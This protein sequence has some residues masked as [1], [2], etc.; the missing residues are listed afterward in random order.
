[1]GSMTRVT[2]AENVDFTWKG[3]YRV[4]GVAALIVGVITYMV[5]KFK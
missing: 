2:D 4:G 1:M 5:K 3:L